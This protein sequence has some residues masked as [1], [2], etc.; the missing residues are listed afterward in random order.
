MLKHK[1]VNLTLMKKI[2]N[3]RAIKGGLIEGGKRG[4]MD[5]GGKN[6]GENLESGKRWMGT[7]GGQ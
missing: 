3:K 1:G 7:Q 2:Q 6:L 5:G 4:R